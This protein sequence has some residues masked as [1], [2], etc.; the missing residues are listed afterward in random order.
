MEGQVVGVVLGMCAAEA[1]V[2][3]CS[4]QEDEVVVFE[5]PVDVLKGVEFG[6]VVVKEGGF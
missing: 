1:V 3:G 5:H 6:V 4:G 2:V